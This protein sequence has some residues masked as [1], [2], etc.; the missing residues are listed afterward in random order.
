MLDD[1]RVNL[2]IV[3]IS[4]KMKYMFVQNVT[5]TEIQNSLTSKCFSRR[6]KILQGLL[7]GYEL[8]HKSVFY[9][10]NCAKREARMGG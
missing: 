8:I 10:M 7:D 3:N 5:R 9:H 2:L 1:V 4:D 6:A